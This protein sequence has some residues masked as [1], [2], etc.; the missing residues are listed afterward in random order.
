MLYHGLSGLRRNGL[1]SSGSLF[2]AISASR[3]FASSPK[4]PELLRVGLDGVPF[5]TRRLVDFQH[6]WLPIWLHPH[7]Y[8]AEVEVECLHG[9]FGRIP[10]PLAQI[11]LTDLTVVETPPAIEGPDPWM[12]VFES[13]PV[14]FH[15]GPHALTL[16]DVD[17]E[18]P[19]KF[20]LLD[21][22]VRGHVPAL[23]LGEEIGAT[24][25]VRFPP[26]PLIR[27]FAPSTRELRHRDSRVSER[28][29]LPELVVHPTSVEDR[30]SLGD[31]ECWVL[32]PTHDDIPRRQTWRC[33]LVPPSPCSGPCVQEPL[34]QGPGSV[35]SPSARDVDQATP[36]SS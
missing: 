14:H 26:K 31:L 1:R 24:R 4:G 8:S 23:G 3:N 9:R 13:F 11:L 21:P 29:E 30:D 10:H 25:V 22:E 5:K 7:I 20:L 27:R 35:T 16:P 34:N 18:L 2:T 15:P 36:L 17:P 6:N 33:P 19:A 28:F 32:S 12:G